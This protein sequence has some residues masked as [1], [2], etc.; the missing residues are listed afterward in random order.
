M[1]GKTGRS[2]KRS[3]SARGR[4]NRGRGRPVKR[5]FLQ[6]AVDRLKSAITTVALLATGALVASWWISWRE[7]DVPATQNAESPAVESGRRLKVEVLNGSG[8]PGAAG[9]IGDLLLEFGYDV[10]AVDNAESFDYPLTHVLDRSGAGDDVSEVAR[11]IG[12]D[13]IAIVLDPDLLLDATVILGK[14]WRALTAGG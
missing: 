12:V 7:A 6:I 4:S 13:S 5:G 14:D 11:S 2:R 1:A 10:V 8:E 9:V 3:G